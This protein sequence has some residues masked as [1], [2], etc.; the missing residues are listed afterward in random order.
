MNGRARAL[1]GVLGGAATLAATLPLTTLFA[2]TAAWFRPSLLLVALVV[3]T[4]AGLRALTPV[5]TLVVAAQLLVLLNG[6]ALLHGQGHLWKGIVPVPET[7]RALGL[8]LGDAY[9][10]ITSYTVPAPANRGVVLGISLLVGLTALAVDALAVTLRSPAAAGVPLLTA[11]LASATN[12]GDGLAAWFVVPPALAWLAM[13]GRQGVRSLRVWGMVNPR[14]STVSDPT[15]SFATA[16]RVA[17]VLALSAAVV[18]PGLVPHFPPTFLAQGLGRSDNGRGGGSDVRLSSSI[19]IAR[20]LGD[21]STDPVIVYRTSDGSPPPL[22]VGILDTYRRGRWTSSSDFT[23]VPLDG[24]LP[25]TS[26]APTVRRTVQRIEVTANGIGIPQVALPEN[27]TGSPFPD[28][29]WH[30]TSAGLAELTA[31]VGSYTADYV[32]L[33]PSDGDFTTDLAANA[34][35]RDDLAVDPQAEGRV[36]ELLAQITSP[37]QSP[38]EV[39]RAIQDHLRG[40]DYTYSQELA[41]STAEGSTAEEPLVRFLQTRRGYCVQF[42]SAMIMLAREAGIPARMAV[43]F[44]PGS[45]DGDTRT[46]RVNDAH[47]WPELY[48]PRLGWTRFEPTPGVRS[49]TAPAYSVEQAAGAGASSAPTPSSSASAPTPTDNRLQQDVPAGTPDAGAAGSTGGVGRFLAANALTLLVLLLVVVL[50]LLVPTAAAVARSRA[51][52]RA[53]DEAERVEAEWESLVLRLGD[54]GV[55]AADGAT[56]RQASAQLSKAAYLTAD[57]GAALGRVVATLEGARYAPPGGQVGDVA[58]DARAVWR[59]ALS[60]RRRVDRARALL[61]PE[62]GLRWWR[63]ALRPRGRSDA[64]AEDEHAPLGP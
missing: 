42:A 50:L 22:R 27:A 5:R 57:E 4:G 59:A 55:T 38:V 29:T 24:R 46:V 26:A 14:S 23:F 35:E 13:L 47:A 54:I 12:S 58:A 44:L 48:F 9:A 8:L 60:R 32:S 43:G 64:P 49:G 61:L 2:P 16:G 51:R 62:E 20:D 56:P 34:P 7:G 63:T 37:G 18:V 40:P 36:R 21:R 41:D 1:D 31:P 25:G 3:A 30:V 33:Q 53:R 52:Q 17:G 19:D 6:T 10:T 39:A 15:S 45:P 11:Y 28:G